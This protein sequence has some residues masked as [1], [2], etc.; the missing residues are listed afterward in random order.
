LKFAG[1][2]EKSCSQEQIAEAMSNYYKKL[3]RENG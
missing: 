1:L 3:A 2:D